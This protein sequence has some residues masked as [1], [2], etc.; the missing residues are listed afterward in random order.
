MPPFTGRHVPLRD[1]AGTSTFSQLGRQVS[2]WSGG[3]CWS[4]VMRR[5]LAGNQG[6]SPAS[7]GLAHTTQNPPAFRDRTNRPCGDL[8]SPVVG[9]ALV[10]ARPSARW[11]PGATVQ[12]P[13]I[14]LVVASTGRQGG[15]TQAKA[16]EGVSGSPHPTHHKRTMTGWTVSPSHVVFPQAR[17]PCCHHSLCMAVSSQLCGG[18]VPGQSAW[19]CFAL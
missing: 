19:S 16:L 2:G 15:G 14:E 4:D 8:G 17:V 11:D 12:P 13:C 7:S 3:R 10:G 1:P 6:A 9:E 5:G 18:T